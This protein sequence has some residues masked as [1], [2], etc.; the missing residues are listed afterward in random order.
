MTE[1]RTVQSQDIPLWWDKIEPL[2]QRSCQ[3]GESYT[4]L[5]HIYE[6]LLEAKRQ[7]WLGLDGEDIQVVALTQICIYPLTKVGLLT[8]VA[9]KRMDEWQHF[10][11]PISLWFKE[12][13]CKVFR[14]EGRKGWAR[15]MKKHGF[16]EEC[17]VISKPL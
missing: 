4:T 6:E 2:L 17:V 11:H 14:L 9:G 13:G 7:L 16:D 3:V 8:H 5:E 12:M 15:E 10:I 1:L